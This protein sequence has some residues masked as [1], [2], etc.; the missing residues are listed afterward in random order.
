MNDTAV[1]VR[2]AAIAGWWTVLFAVLF[3]VLLWLAYLAT[4]SSKPAWV[5]ALAGPGVSWKMVQ[6]IW[7]HVFSTYRLFI[8]VLLVGVVWLTLWARQLRKRDRADATALG[9]PENA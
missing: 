6:T 4:L 9:A 3:A 7:L 5:L 2:C 1:K 8:W